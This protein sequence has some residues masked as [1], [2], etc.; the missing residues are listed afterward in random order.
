M[1]IIMNHPQTARRGREFCLGGAKIGWT[2]KTSD[3]NDTDNKPGPSYNELEAAKS[4]VGIKEAQP[5]MGSIHNLRNNDTKE[6]IEAQ[7]SDVAEGV[8][9]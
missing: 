2:G 8:K 3:N 5:K 1:P 4:L 9:K 7:D 6:K